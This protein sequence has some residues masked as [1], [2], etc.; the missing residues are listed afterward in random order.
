MEWDAYLAVVILQAFAHA[1]TSWEV[2]TNCR[3]C[4]AVIKVWLLLAPNGVVGAVGRKTQRIGS[5]YRSV[6]SVDVRVKSPGL[7]ARAQRDYWRVLS[8]EQR[9]L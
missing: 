3:R 9:I 6:K 8:T 4:C 5:E 1:L 7:N 2:P